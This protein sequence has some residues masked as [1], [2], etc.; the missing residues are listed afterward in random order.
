M[1]QFKKLTKLAKKLRSPKGCPWDKSR[2]LEDMA[3]YLKEEC[4]EAMAA[5]HKKDHKNLKEELGDLLFTIVLTIQIAEE[6]KLFNAKGVLDDIAKKI[7]SRHTWVFGKDKASTPE[8]ALKM[9]KRN[10]KAKK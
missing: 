8:E 5:I 7:I 1:R 2:K 6:E 3:K 10:K 9:W 4:E